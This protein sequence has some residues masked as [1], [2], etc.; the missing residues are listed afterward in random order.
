M[1]FLISFLSKTMTL[2]PGD[3]IMTGTPHG[4][5][6]MKDGDTI[7]VE[8]SGVGVLTNPVRDRVRP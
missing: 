5:G 1:P 8:V 7:E 3:L 6:P 4:V 2:F